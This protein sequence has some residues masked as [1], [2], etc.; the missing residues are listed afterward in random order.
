MQFIIS[1]TLAIPTPA[2]KDLARYILPKGYGY[3]NGEYGYGVG[4]YGYATLERIWI[5]ASCAFV[6]RMSKQRFNPHDQTWYRL[7][8][9]AMDYHRFDLAR[10]WLQ[11][12]PFFEKAPETCR[13]ALLRYVDR[14]YLAGV[15]FLVENGLDPGMELLV[16]RTG[17]Q[18]ASERVQKPRFSATQK[19]AYEAI[20]RYLRSAVEE[21][22]KRHKPPGRFDDYH[23]FV[24]ALL[25][26]PSLDAYWMFTRLRNVAVGDGD[27][28]ADDEEHELAVECGCFA[29]GDAAD[30]DVDE[31]IF[32][33][34]GTQWPDNIYEV[35]IRAL[36]LLPFDEA[37][38]VYDRMRH[39]SDD[40]ELQDLAW[41]CLKPRAAG[42]MDVDYLRP[43]YGNW[44]Y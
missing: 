15:K 25:Y 34:D 12:A 5:V 37:S 23:L 40:I 29:M 18:I 2:K 1:D 14:G 16:G 30:N 13:L 7:L 22:E 42:R 36:K 20:A 3:R 11:R 38:R 41:D 32:Y 33:S 26:M 24:Y 28:D 21:E 4:E 43:L 27:F 44:G 9:L 35:L 31:D 6:R 8:Q 39:A 10:I 17:Q 19:P